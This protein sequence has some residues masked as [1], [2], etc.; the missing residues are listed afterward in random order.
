MRILPRVK[1]IVS[2]VLVTIFWIG[3]IRIYIFCYGPISLKTNERHSR[4]AIL[5]RVRKVPSSLLVFDS[6]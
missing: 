2:G 3:T 1:Y 6:G 4:V 5:L